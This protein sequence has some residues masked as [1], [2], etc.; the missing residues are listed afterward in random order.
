LF[1]FSNN[2]ETSPTHDPTKTTY[3]GALL[4]K[5]KKEF[6]ESTLTLIDKK[7]RKDQQTYYPIDN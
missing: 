7:Q 3:Y 5:L 2:F 1:T 4:K 6:V